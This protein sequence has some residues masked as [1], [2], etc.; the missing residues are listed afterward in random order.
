[1]KKLGTFRKPT[2]QKVMQGTFRADQAQEI[3]EPQSPSSIKKPPAY[4]GKHGRKL[5]TDLAE[6]LVD[7]GMLTVLDWTTLELCCNAYDLYRE[8]QEAITRPGNTETGRPKGRSLTEYLRDEDGKLIRI[9]YQ[10]YDRYMTA[11]KAMGLSP[12]ARKGM[13]IVDNK[14]HEI[15]V[16]ERIL[17]EM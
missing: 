11:V 17:N 3:P 16:T 14:P 1:M 2:S 12:A 6:E 5:W 8:A 7:L 10:Q 4:M 13:V 15:S 9:M